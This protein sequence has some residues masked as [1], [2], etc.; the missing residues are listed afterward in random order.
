MS[1]NELADHVVKAFRHAGLPAFLEGE[2]GSDDLAGAVVNVE[3]DAEMGSAAV[4]VGWRC[5]VSKIHAALRE[6]SAGAADTPPAKYPGI[7]GTHMQSALVKILLGAGI[8][9]TPNNDSTDSD[10]V[11]V[12]ARVS[13][14]PTALQPTFVP[15]QP[16]P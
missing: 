14:L 5:E 8:I 7:I 2:D 13:D 4:S 10:R 9:A 15:P 1:V 12:F 3:P 6:L 11:L 16:T